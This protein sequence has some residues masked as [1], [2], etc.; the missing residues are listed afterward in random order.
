MYTFPKEQGILY[1]PA[2]SS[3]GL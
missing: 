2:K 1:I 3:G